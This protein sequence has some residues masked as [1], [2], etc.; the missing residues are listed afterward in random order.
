M[1]FRQFQISANGRALRIYRLG[2]TF[3]GDANEDSE[4]TISR[5]GRVKRLGRLALLPHVNRL[6]LAAAFDEAF[7]VADF[8][9]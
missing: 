8:A 5:I 2:I 1:S 4:A 9:A 6:A 7:D 3:I